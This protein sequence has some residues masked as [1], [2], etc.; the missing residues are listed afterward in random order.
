MM[1]TLFVES[2]MMS[3][4]FVEGTRIEFVK[5]KLVVGFVVGLVGLSVALP[6]MNIEIQKRMMDLMEMEQ[7]ND[8]LHPGE[9][10][11]S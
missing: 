3:M 2:T 10:H 1:S 4:F 8:I 7:L 5:M 6:A 9:L 11:F